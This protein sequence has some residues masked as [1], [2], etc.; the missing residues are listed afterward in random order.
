MAK[1]KEKE[2]RVLEKL[3]ANVERIRRHQTTEASQEPQ[4]HYAGNLNLY[5]INLLYINSV[6]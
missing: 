5:K 3:K 2:N 4:D 1:E 6:V